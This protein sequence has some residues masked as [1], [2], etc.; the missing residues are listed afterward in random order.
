MT[1]ENEEM[2]NETQQKMFLYCLVVYSV[3]KS[4]LF[5]W[6]EASMHVRLISEYLTPKRSSCYS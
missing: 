5:I 1:L 3:Q 6:F 2:Q 4:D